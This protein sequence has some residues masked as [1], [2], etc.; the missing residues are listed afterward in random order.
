[1]VQQPAADQPP[2]Q[3]TLYS[4]DR[5]DPKAPHQKQH[6]LSPFVSKL[7]FRLRHAGISYSDALGSKPAAPRGKIPYVKFADDGKVIGDTSFIFRELSARGLV[8]HEGEGDDGH[9]KGEGV[10][11]GLMVEGHLYWFLMYERWKENYPL[12]LE[13]GPFCHLGVGMR[14]LA[15]KGLQGFLRATLWFQGV[16]RYDFEEVK[17]FMRE[18][19][20]VLGGY[21][22]NS[23]ERMVEGGE[24]R[25]GVFWILGGKKAT[26]A[27]FSCWGFLVGVL[28]LRFQPALRGMVMEHEALVEYVKRIHDKYFGDYG[29]FEKLMKDR[30]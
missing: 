8:P 2:P 7:Q 28:V 9:G 29:D 14:H 4:F 11:L 22:K 6:S 23:W 17:G 27:D 12:L 25:K 5:P 13:S 26:E 10:C 19:V 24:Q 21:A 20:E 16:G 3:L 15:T 30:V 18:G 1:M